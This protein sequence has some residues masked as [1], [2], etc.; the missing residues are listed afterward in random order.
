VLEVD[1]A[2]LVRPLEGVEHRIEVLRRDARLLKVA[3][4]A[5]MGDVEADDAQIKGPYRRLAQI[6]D[7]H[8]Y[9]SV[10]TARDEASWFVSLLE[11]AVVHHI[12]LPGKA[13]RVRLWRLGFKAASVGPINPVVLE[14]A[15]RYPLSGGAIERAVLA[16]SGRARTEAGEPLVR[17]EDVTEACRAQ[18][19]PRLS[20]VAQRIV[21]TFTWDDLILPDDARE[22]MREL[23]AYW[24][25]MRTVYEEWGYGRLLPYGRGLSA[26]FAGPPG[27]GKTMAAGIIGGELGMEVFRVDLSRTVSKYIG[28]TEKN[29]GRVFDEAAKSQSILL[30]DEADSL[31]SKR[32]G[33]KSSVDRYANL[34]V[35]Y[36]LQRMEDFDGVTV[37]TTNLEGSLDDAFRRRIR[38]RV[39]FPAP[40]QA[41]REALW[42]RMVPEQAHV[43]GTLDFAILAL[44]YDLSGG[45]IK[46]AAL[47]AAFFA[48]ERGAGIRMRDLR[49]AARLECEK[50]GKI[51]RVSDTIDD[52]EEG[53]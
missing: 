31:F 19:T 5:D 29:L 6:L 50:L 44:D 40:D 9:G 26:L 24:K 1:A 17:L 52:D 51:V 3:L 13:E 42:T 14:A 10:V 48:A 45:H 28:E 11:Q 43:D 2:S 30:F 41:T 8:P 35:N 23:V 49:R 20:G 53:A 16:A 22:A 33:V 37:L 4:V 18:L 36:L 32:T 7:E 46:N 25:N 27:T 38:F 21:T 34:E 15:C 39:Q 47:R 12:P